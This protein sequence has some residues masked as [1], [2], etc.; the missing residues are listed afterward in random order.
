[1]FVVIGATG[2]VGR[3]AVD[4]LH[5]A[6]AAVTAVTRNP[7]AAQLPAGVRVIKGDP[8]TAALP[9]ATWDDVEGV[10]LASRGAIATAPA[11]LAAAAARGA[12]RVVVISALT[13]RFPAGEPRFA[14][15]FR[16]LEHAAANSGMAW[17]ALR[18]A[19]FA[20]NTLAWAA[21]LRGGDVVRGAYG[22]AATSPIHE[23]DIA[24]IA[25]LALTE[26]TH[27]DARYLLTGPQS[28]N[29]HDKARIL[30]AA[31]GRDLSF[32][33]VAPEQVRAAMLAQGLPAEIPARLLGSLADYAREPAPTTDLV[34]TLLGRPARDFA[35]WA[36]D[37]ISAF[38]NH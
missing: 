6:G 38:D 3:A 25:A 36:N 27:D 9:E 10:L 2:C 35:T 12:R 15:G 31:L 18:C 4:A 11:L 37:N 23:R 22:T 32:T 7:G 26:D 5:T 13:V 28:L 14:D 34:A 24:E 19:D 1:M 8:G 29:Q 17:T 30:G 21:Q 33:E 20:A 16:A